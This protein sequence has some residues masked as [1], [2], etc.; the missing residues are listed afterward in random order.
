MKSNTPVVFQWLAAIFYSKAWNPID[1]PIIFHFSFFIFHFY[2][3]FIART[4]KVSTK[5][6]ASQN[7]SSATANRMIIATKEIKKSNQSLVVEVFVVSSIF[8]C[9][10]MRGEGK[11]SF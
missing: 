1:S 9:F 5:G 2:I 3:I 10:I 4:K 11:K 7:H 8:Q 6:N